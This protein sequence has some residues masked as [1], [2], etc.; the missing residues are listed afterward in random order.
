MKGPKRRRAHVL[1]RIKERVGTHINPSK[2]EGNLKHEDIIFIKK[3]SCSR[4]IG[5][6]IIDNTPIKIVYGKECKK[7][8]TVLPLNYDFE[9]P[10]GE[11]WFKTE[12]N[13]KLY[14][15]K[16]FPDCYIETE[17]KR[18]MTKFEI[19]NRETME[20][21]EKKYVNDIFTHIFNAVWK[22]YED[23]KRNEILSNS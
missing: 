11:E 14:R 13:N 7:V 2:I 19:Q 10:K 17:N 23:Y 22:Q 3:V 12:Y 5:Y 8:I 20:W 4:S 1:K 9:F 15:M 16:I 18:T 21:K 6:L